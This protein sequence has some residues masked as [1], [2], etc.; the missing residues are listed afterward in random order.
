[1][2]QHQTNRQLK[3]MGSE[4]DAIHKKLTDARSGGRITLLKAYI[5]LSG[6]GWM[7]SAL[8]LGGGSLAASLYL[9]IV[10]GT[11][12]LWLQ[13]LAVV[14]GI[15]MLSAVFYVVLSTGK[16]PFHLLDC[17]MGPV[18]AWSWLLGA[19]IAC[20]V[21][22]FPQFS[23]ATAVVQENLL[24]DVFGPSGYFDPPVS[25]LIIC[26][27]MA[28]VAAGLVWAYDAGIRAARL[29]DIFLKSLI[30][31]MFLAFF[32]VLIRVSMS[33]GGV[34]WSNVVS[35]LVPDF[36]ML[37]TPVDSFKPYIL[38]VDVE[39]RDFW[40]DLITR[41]QRDLIIST[42]AIVVGVNSTVLLSYSML[43]KGWNRDFRELAI[44]DLST[45]FFIPFV[46]I[47]GCMVVVS[48]TLFHTKPVEG[49]VEEHV[50]ASKNM[51]ERFENIKRDRVIHELQKTGE[52]ITET[53]V[54]NRMNNLGQADKRM[55]AMLV[56]RDA[57][58]LSQ[59]LQP[60]TGDLFSHFIFGLGVLGL[61]IS[62]VIIQMVTW[63]FV[64][65]EI[66]NLPKHGWP[67]RIGSLPPAVGILAPF[68][69][70]GKAQFWLVVP[71]S[72]FVAILLPIA[73]ISFALLMNKKSILGVDMPTGPRRAGWNTLMALA[74]LFALFGSM[75]SMWSR[76]G[77]WAVVVVASY[78]LLALAAY[79]IRNR[80]FPRHRKE[81]V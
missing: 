14:M 35:G 16:N 59:S 37:T 64:T 7:Q 26:I 70:T 62:T 48:A 22:A 52:S 17:H 30:A 27:V 44:F 9:G 43:K 72:L 56:H 53:E 54:I 28:S 1:M 2:S 29:F 77:W 68:I 40:I 69:W 32:G 31:M 19:G 66:L 57:F 20:V 39:F 55:A 38:A 63:G 25:Q 49:L 42:A 65:C 67:Y 24:P 36:S 41:E 21:W 75:W 58:D 78:L 76:I 60:L 80:Y 33:G 10:G 5:G 51:V 11:E 34:A 61:A 3:E 6:P 73:Y 13:P 45:G 47:T 15:I 79:L 12:F 74:T 18:I 50:T 8:T 71:T 81:Q 46:L 4:T 23:L